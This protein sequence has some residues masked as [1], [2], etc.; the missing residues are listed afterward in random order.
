MKA[1][2][3]KSNYFV[4]YFGFVVGALLMAVSIEYFLY[5]NRLIDGGIIGISLITARLTNDA[6][7]PYYLIIFNIPFIYLAYRYIRKSF[8]IQMGIAVFLFA[9]FLALLKLMPHYFAADSLEGIVIGG[10]ILGAGA[11]LIIRCGGCTDGTEILAIIVNRRKGYTVGQIVLAINIF[12]FVLYGIIF[13]DWHIAL[14]SLMMYIVAFKMMDIVIAGLEELKSVMILSEKPDQIKKRIMSELNLGLTIIKGR[15]G[16]SGEDKDIL[17]IIVERL[18]LAGLKELVISEDPTAFMA[19]E[20]L[21]E[22]AYGRQRS[23]IAP[24]KKTRRKKTKRLKSS[25]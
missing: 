3:K 7:L 16:Y 17:F 11:G 2:P 6:L 8:L 14:K 23:H 15:G 20:N 5:P 24:T 4:T 19:I 18:D 25:N 1:T 21:H 22:V 12:I 9:L 13:L 10:A